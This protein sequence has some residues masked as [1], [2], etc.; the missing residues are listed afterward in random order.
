MEWVYFSE[1][2]RKKMDTASRV[3]NLDVY[4]CISLQAEAPRKCISSL[5]SP[6]CIDWVLK[7]Y[8]SNQFKRRKISEMYTLQMLLGENVAPEKNIL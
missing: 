3:Q 1:C 4:V 2:R 7:P 6:S 8:K 5:V